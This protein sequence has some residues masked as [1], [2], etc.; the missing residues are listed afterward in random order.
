MT[1]STQTSA[2]TCI[3]TYP[4][5]P[6]LMVDCDVTLPG[7]ILKWRMVGELV[8]ASNY[9]WIEAYIYIGPAK[10]KYTMGASIDSSKYTYCR[11]ANHDKGMRM[12]NA[13][14]LRVTKKIST[15]WRKYCEWNKWSDGYAE[16]FT[17]GEVYFGLLFPDKIPLSAMQ[18]IFRGT[19][20]VET[21][22]LNLF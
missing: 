14:N 16:Q 18:I 9:Q 7:K 10:Q 1:N 12:N 3:A 8:V 13:A 5:H 17:A 6:G 21:E 22:D 19:L 2:S 15:P 20:Y 11:E 4:I